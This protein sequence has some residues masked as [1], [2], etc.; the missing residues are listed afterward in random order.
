MNC[1]HENCY[2][3]VTQNSSKK[4]DGYCQFC[5]ANM[6]PNDERSLFITRKS[7]ELKVVTYLL[8]F[9]KEFIYDTPFYV[10]L[11]G[12]C[13]ATKR[14]IDLRK[15]INNT[16]L[17][18]E[19]DENQH[20][21]YIKQNDID[22]YNDL[23]IDFSGKYIFI[24][25]NPDRYKNKN[26]KYQDL[27]FDKRMKILINIINLIIM[28]ID[29]DMNDELIEIYNIFYDD[30]KNDNINEL[31]DLLNDD[32]SINNT[33]DKYGIF[34]NLSM[35]DN[36]KLEEINA[37]IKQKKL[38]TIICEYC[39][40][41][42]CVA[43]KN[44]HEKSK[45]CIKNRL[46]DI[47]IK[48][49]SCKF[50]NYKFDQKF[51]KDEHEKNMLCRPKDIYYKLQLEIRN[52]DK[53]LEEKDKEIEI[54][55]LENNELNEQN[56]MIIVKIKPPYNKRLLFLIILSTLSLIISIINMSMK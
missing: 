44:R 16:M 20:K 40:K 48:C 5:F 53:L 14:R 33:N 23:F 2:Q 56:K 25:Y 55:D 13:C 21:Y 39:N 6:Y 8:N 4:Y 22:R 17:C 11:E 26:N 9:F 3:L 28:R 45:A 38:E 15:L 32:M 42:I 18:I 50:C 19:I 27:D 31:N 46:N 10:D 41:T 29:N 52:K 36:D 1:K 47:D 12:G 34:L 37:K 54:K 43:S 51:N 30:T 7:K 24:R 35:V 49:F